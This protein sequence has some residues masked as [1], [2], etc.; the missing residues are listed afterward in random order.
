MNIFKQIKRRREIK[1]CRKSFMYCVHKAKEEV[2][3]D[4]DDYE[5]WVLLTSVYLNRE[6]ELRIKED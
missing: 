5:A 6:L 2:N 3:G 4:L 1:R